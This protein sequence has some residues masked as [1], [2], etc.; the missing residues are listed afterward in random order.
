MEGLRPLGFV[1]ERVGRGTTATGN[2]MLIDGRFLIVDE[3]NP[4]HRLV[5]G[6]GNGSSLL[7]TQV[8][9]IRR[10]KPANLMEFTP[11]ATAGCCL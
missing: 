3:G 5:I 11:N 10:R 4:L 9:S 6:F 7:Q 8:Q 1:V 2:D